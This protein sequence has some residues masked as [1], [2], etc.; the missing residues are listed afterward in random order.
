MQAKYLKRNHKFGIELPKI[1]EL[2][3]ALYAKN[4]NTFCADAIATERK[5]V[6]VTFKIVPDVTKAPIINPFVQY[7]NR[8]IPP[9]VPT[10][11]KHSQTPKS[12]QTMLPRQSTALLKIASSSILVRIFPN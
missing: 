12:P 9:A 8:H 1:V 6:K 5:N 11:A 3:L 4:G 7:H 10:V 2:A